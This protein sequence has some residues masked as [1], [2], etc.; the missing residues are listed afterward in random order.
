M[1]HLFL[2]SASPRRADLLTQV[3]ADFTVLPSPNID[4][5]V[6]PN[7]TAHDY[8]CRLAVEKAR[9]GWRALEDVDFCIGTLAV[10][11]N[12]A[13]VLGADTCVVLGDDILGKPSDAASAKVMLTALSGRE[14]RVITAVSLIT[15]EKGHTACSDTRVVFLP[16]SETHIERYIATGEPFDKAGAYGIQGR[17]AQFVASLTGSYSGVVGLPLAETCLLL[18]QAGIEL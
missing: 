12:N 9:A 14:H 2:A 10:S 7:E 1:R 11:P 6:R 17:G 13:I 3:G 4:E 5:R 15:A 16:L 18:E 8:V